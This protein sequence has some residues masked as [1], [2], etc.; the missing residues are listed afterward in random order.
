MK[1]RQI[2]NEFAKKFHS[3][4][5]DFTRRGIGIEL[6]IPIVSMD[7]EVVNRSVIQKM[8]AFF[9]DK[10]FRLNR[11]NLTNY[12]TSASRLNQ[13][14]ANH[15][16]YVTDTIMTDVGNSV[17]EI[18]L[19]PQ[20]NLHKTQESLSEIIGLLITYLN[21]QDCKMLGYGIQPL[22]PPSRKLL[23]PKERYIFYEKFSSSNH[24]ISKSEGTDSHLLTIMASNQCHVSI[25]EKDAI[26]AI[27]VL[28]AL[29]GLQ[30]IFNANSPIWRGKIDKTYK[31]S[32][33]AFW[34]HCYSDRRNQVGIPPKFQTIN[35][36][37]L[38]LLEFKPMLI[39]RE[40]LLQVLDKS[41][42][43]D[44]M[45]D[46]TP[47]LGQTL[48][49]EKHHIQSEIEDIHHLNAFCYF[50]ARLAPKFGTIESRMCCQQPPEAS[51]APT[52]LTLGLVSN[53]EQANK[54][55]KAYSWK[56]WKKLRTE[57]LEHTFNTSIEGENILP[58]LNEFLEV[59]KNGLQK[60]ELGEEVFL[61]PYYKRLDLQKSPADEAIEIFEKQGITGILNH[62][63]FKNSPVHT[64]PTLD[65]IPV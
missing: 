11:D 18:A 19:A 53:L 51:L 27:N 15:F 26:T 16:N 7:G 1:Y 49:G 56:T 47:A 64:K 4:D 30:I 62:F 14:S 50:N 39:Q 28:N 58:L 31:A 22:T 55:V 54:L 52:A 33:E 24:I 9:E 10:G 13:Q 46:Q 41:T 65:T 29:S 2:F 48:E 37:L 57:A 63:S 44:F 45:F 20:D 21:T 36:Y 6:E 8:F 5:K 32:R 17:I 23:M 42:F 40:K 60:R 25:G 59:A 43:K 38:Y 61:E 35:D 3:N 12:I 34:E